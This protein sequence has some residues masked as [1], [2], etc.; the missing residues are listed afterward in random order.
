MVTAVEALNTAGAEGAPPPD[1][2]VGAPAEKPAE[3]A[4]VAPAAKPTPTI[5]KAAEQFAASE[6]AANE[7]E[8][9]RLREQNADLILKQFPEEMRPGVQRVLDVQKDANYLK[10]ERVKLDTEKQGLAKD[11]ILA[12]FK[13]VGVTA[14]FLENCPD[15]ASMRTMAERIK[16]LGVKPAEGE[17]GGEGEGTPNPN[18]MNEKPNA[19]VAGGGPQKSAIE[20]FHGKGVEIGMAGLLGLPIDAV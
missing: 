8:V 17:G 4:A 5:D 7:G 10:S 14:E 15:E 20:Q 18:L 1:P 6:A 16:A 13:D 9:A 11:R 3:G 12:E 19:T 2:A